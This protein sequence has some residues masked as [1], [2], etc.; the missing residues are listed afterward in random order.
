MSFH[1]K[2][3]L[4]V[5]DITL[6]VLPSFQNISVVKQKRGH[7]RNG[8]KCRT[9]RIPSNATYCNNHLSYITPQLIQGLLPIELLHNLTLT[10]DLH[11][12][13]ASLKQAG[14]GT[15]PALIRSKPVKCNLQLIQGSHI[16]LLGNMQL[17]ISHSL[18]ALILSYLYKVVILWQ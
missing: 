1:M 5:H 10:L 6:A 3:I 7:A 9:S 13:T 17:K 12:A 4:M 14:L 11:V 15:N 18:P 8:F 2:Y 16:L